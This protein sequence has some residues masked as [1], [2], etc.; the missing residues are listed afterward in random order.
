MASRN[1]P[2]GRKP[3]SYYVDYTKRDRNTHDRR[4]AQT[5]FGSNNSR[6]K[7]TP[8]ISFGQRGFLITSIDEVKA[9]LEMRNVFEEYFED[10]YNKQSGDIDSQQHKS[11]ED[12]IE[13]ELQQIRRTRPFKQV[14]THCRNAIFLK[15]MDDFKNVDP[16]RLVDRFFDEMKQ[17]QEARTSNTFK[18]LPVLDT[19]RITSACAKE[20]I[21]NLILELYKDIESKTYFIEFQSR[22]N[23]K[24]ESD[25][26][27][28]M[29]ESVAEAVAEVKPSWSVRR[30]DADYM[31][32]I[33]ALKN[34]CCLSVVENY[35]RRSRYNV[36]EFCKNYSIG[37]NRPSEE[38][39]PQE[40]Q[41]NEQ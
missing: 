23:F 37:D 3:R 2:E 10:I 1:A 8:E 9:Y 33:V 16:I 26:K 31:I 38:S 12:E 22:G 20:S 15:I 27:K 25:D 11:T 4:R 40:V 41:L 35:F 17:K 39:P 18:V 6:Y 21:S 7:E 36:V 28:K 24:L 34:V 30:E 5:N 29:I 13:A 14:R 32:I 19:F